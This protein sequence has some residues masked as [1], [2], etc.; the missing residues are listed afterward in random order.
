[1][2]KEIIRAL[3]VETEVKSVFLWGPETKWQGGVPNIL[4]FSYFGISHSAG[5]VFLLGEIEHFPKPM[6]Q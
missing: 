1:M 6:S 2:K 5:E 4:F 3:A